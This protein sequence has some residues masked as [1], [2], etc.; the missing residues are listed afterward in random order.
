MKNGGY[1]PALNWWVYWIPADLDRGLWTG[2]GPQTTVDGSEILRS[3]VEVGSLSDNLQGNFITFQVIVSGFLPTINSMDRTPKMDCGL[4]NHNPKRSQKKKPWSLTNSPEK[5]DGT[6][7]PLPFPKVRR[8]RNFS[9]D[10]LKKL[11]VGKSKQIFRNSNSNPDTATRWQLFGNKLSFCHPS[12]L[13]NRTGVPVNRGPS[14]GTQQEIHGE[15]L[16]HPQQSKTVLNPT[17]GEEKLRTKVGRKI[18]VQPKKTSKK[19]QFLCPF[20]QR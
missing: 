10:I 4:T 8:Y 6:G 17:R 11:Q 1:S 16:S 19:S 7:R 5:K 15:F 2:A 18:Q 20:L 9:G 13:W 12:H 14:W 3:P